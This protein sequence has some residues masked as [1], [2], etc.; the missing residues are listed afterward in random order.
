[1][2][3]VRVYT[4][5]INVVFTVR[6]ES[7]FY[8]KGEYMLKKTL[9]RLTLVGVVAISAVSLANAATVT[10]PYIGGQLGWGDIHASTGDLPGHSNITAA[11]NDFN[12]VNWQNYSASVKNA[13]SGLAGRLFLGYQ[14]TPNWAVELGYLKFHDAD[15]KGDYTGSSNLVGSEEGMSIPTNGENYSYKGVVKE[16]AFDLVGKG[17]LPLEN[18]FSLYGKL[19]IAYV[20]QTSTLNQS[21]THSGIVPPTAMTTPAPTSV[22]VNQRY[23]S[24]TN[25]FLPEFGVGASYDITSNMPVD[26]SWTH[27]QK[28]SGTIESADFISLG[29]AYKFNA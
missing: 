21:T 7:N 1:M 12:A 24:D 19:G 22:T 29:L 10:G 4:Y 25:R 27:I 2:T 11:V 20:Q 6:K 13:S 3:E 16:H 18:G 5:F 14:F 8:L 23:S 28:T 15:L 9:L 26:L 17:I